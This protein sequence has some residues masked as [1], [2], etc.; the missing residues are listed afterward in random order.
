MAKKTNK[1]TSHDIQNEC[2]KLMAFHILR[3]LSKDIQENGWYAIMADECTDVSNIE[4]FTI[5]IRWVDKYLESHESFIRLYEVDSITSDTLVSAIKDTLVRLNVKLTDCRGQCYDGASNMSGSRR[6][7]AAQ[8]CGDEKKAL[9]T[10]CYGHALNLAVSDTI[11]Q[12][13]VCRDAL[14]T[15][16][17]I[18]KLGKFSPKRD[19]ALNESGPNFN[20]WMK[21]LYLMLPSR[22]SAL[23]DGLFEERQ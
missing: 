23:R 11:K 7:V 19:A 5:C 14:D 18:T 6:G 1:Y 22:S 17:E 4:Q 13:K 12:S 3:Q 8:I 21:T 20:I 15:V 16:Y 2:V 10:H 9:Y